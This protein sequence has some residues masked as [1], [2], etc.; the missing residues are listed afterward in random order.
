[1]GPWI[2][3]VFRL[4]A[5]GK[6]LR[7]TTFDPFGYTLERRTERRLISDYE[8]LVTEVADN[9][10]A[11]DQDAALALAELPDQIRGFGH[12]KLASIEGIQETQT[13]LT[14]ALYCR[15]EESS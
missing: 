8:A 3:P 9:F 6:H 1:M 5:K 13:A 10:E 4:L 2:L 14:K 11:V 7:G 12:V 15:V